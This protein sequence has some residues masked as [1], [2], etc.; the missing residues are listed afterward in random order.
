MNEN[1]V[2]VL[3]NIPFEVDETA[4]LKELHVSEGSEDA[5]A[6]RNL[7]ETVRGIPKPKAVYKVSYI[8]G[9][10]DDNVCLDGVV[11]KSRVLSA[12]LR[13]VHRVFPYIATCGIE[14]DESDVPSD[15]FIRRYWLDTIKGM[16]LLAGMEYLFS[17]IRGKYLLETTSTMS[18]GEADRDVWPIEQQ[19]LLFGLFGNV[20]ELIG[21]KLTDSLLMIPNKSVSGICFASEVS[22][23]SCQV[24]Q[25]KNCPG[26][27]APFDKDLMESYRGQ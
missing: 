24:C 17:H 2:E 16:A 27:A 3:D 10:D 19:E 5:K 20:D 6:V 4:L 7:L 13:N 21:V 15:D 12:N 9:R 22:F 18:P 26:R 11:F 14:L 1:V 25:R 8:E 23:R